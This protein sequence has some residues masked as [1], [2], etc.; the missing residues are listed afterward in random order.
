MIN[1]KIINNF[2]ERV[3]NPFVIEGKTANDE[4]GTK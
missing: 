3:Q 2:F 1:D 4:G